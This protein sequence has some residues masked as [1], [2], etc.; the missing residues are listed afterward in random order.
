MSRVGGA[1]EGDLAQ[2]VGDRLQ[3]PLAFEG[4]HRDG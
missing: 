3:E 4:Q 2:N 1:T